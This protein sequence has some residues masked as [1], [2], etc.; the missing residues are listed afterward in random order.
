MGN[1]DLTAVH[2]ISAKAF[3]FG[4][5]PIT[6]NLHHKFFTLRSFYR[7]LLARG[8][9]GRSPLPAAL[10]KEP[11]RLV[12]YIYSQTDLRRIVSAAYKQRFWCKIEDVAMQALL[13]LLYGAGLRIGEAL[14]LTMADIDWEQ[15]IL[16][17][18]ETKFYKTRLVPVGPD[19][20]QIMNMYLA[21]RRER[22]HR[23][24][25]DSPFLLTRRGAALNIQLAELSFKRLCQVAHV[26]R[27]DGSRFGPR[28]HDLR[29][30]FA[31]HRLTTWYRQGANVQQLLPQLST[32][33]G[34]V[35]IGCTQRYLTMTPELLHH[36]SV[37]FERYGAPEVSYD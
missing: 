5:G 29:H 22:R 20:F 33:L 34:H 24:D 27:T 21:R 10:P 11:G 32:F 23:E 4:D 1:V 9:V 28:L 25:P 37:Q 35:H 15:R 17:I 30:S 26:R 18:R 16:T 2:D 13:L 19:L 6:S 3:I 7:Y 8:Y 14:R 31:V 12:P 36:A